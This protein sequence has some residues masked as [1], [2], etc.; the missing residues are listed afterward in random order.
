MQNLAQP[1]PS[2]PSCVLSPHF[3]PGLFPYCLASSITEEE[4]TRPTELV[5][6]E[7]L[8]ERLARYIILYGEQRF[9]IYGDEKPP[10]V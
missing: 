8:S 7:G 4:V 6:R 1:S 9:I 2:L 3:L 10:T 5:R